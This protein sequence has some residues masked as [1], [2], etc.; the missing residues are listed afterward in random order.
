LPAC[1]LPP[2]HNRIPQWPVGTVGSIAHTDNLCAA[3]VAYRGAASSLGFDM[4]VDGRVDAHL[5]PV[6][7]T[8]REQRWLDKH[9][10]ENRTKL[11]TL[12]F[13]AKEAW[14]KCQYPLTGCFFEFTDVEM[15]L[16]LAQRTFH[17]RWASNERS[18]AAEVTRIHG[19][20]RHHAG[21]VFTGATLR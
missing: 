4:E 8:P 16:D 15:Q 6:V 9:A 12:L 7:C 10:R 13:S 2:D 21:L 1:T 17:L 14:Y 19:R 3:V 18:I 11:A 20:F 5:E